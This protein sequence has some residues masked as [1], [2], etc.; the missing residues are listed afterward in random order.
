MGRFTVYKERNSHE[1]KTLYPDATDPEIKAYLQDA[2]TRMEVKDQNF[3]KNE[4][5]EYADRLAEE[6]KQ[7]KLDK[8]LSK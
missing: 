1:L 2:W 3:Y 4:Y 7:T 8:W 5:V 6:R